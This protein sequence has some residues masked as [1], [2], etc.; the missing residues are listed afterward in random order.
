MH[1]CGASSLHSKGSSKLLW[2]SLENG[3]TLGG[4]AEDGALKPIPVT[5]LLVIEDQ[6][7]FSIT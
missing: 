1:G 6:E 3:S 4:T 7:L 5:G 2:G